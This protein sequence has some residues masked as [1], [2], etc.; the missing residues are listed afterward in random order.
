MTRGRLIA[1]SLVISLWG[2]GV[3]AAPG[4]LDSTFGVDAIFGPGPLGAGIAK[5]NRTAPYD[6]V[7]AHGLSLQSDGKIVA[8]FG[9]GAVI[10]RFLPSGV[11]DPD[12]ANDGFGEVGAL[13]VGPRREM[14]DVTIQADGK[15]VAVG[16]FHGIELPYPVASI[17]RILPDGSMDAGFGTAGF[18]EPLSSKNEELLAVTLQDDGK[19]V[20]AGRLRARKERFVVRRVLADGAADEEF[21]RRGKIRLRPDRYGG[22][23]LEVLMRDDGRMIAVGRSSDG[24]DVSDVAL[25]GYTADGSRDRDFGDRARVRTTLDWNDIG[26]GAAMQDDGKI[27][28]A[29]SSA[30]FQGEESFVLLR[31]LTDGSLDPDF[32]TAG[33]VVGDFGEEA[34]AYA[35]AIQPDGKIVAAGGAEQDV[36]L[37][38]FLPDGTL[39]SGFGVGGLVRTPIAGNAE[40]AEALAML[41]QPDGK[42]VVSGAACT[43]GMQCFFHFLA[44]Y[45]GN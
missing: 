22:Y 23:P 45:E 25:V 29:A 18:V 28:V 43:D 37:A 10:Y 33:V 6:Y 15:I 17:A 14:R 30:A 44:R 7:N 35:V 24:S 11:P 26:H 16:L 19:I 9:E 4:D 34:E 8:V 39:D 36:A 32:G 27:V 5:I 40:Y 13:I 41:L 38:R 31:Y 21:G 1:T 12:F 20:A 2:A 42:I 3:R